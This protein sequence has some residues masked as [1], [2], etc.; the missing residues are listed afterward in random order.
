[1]N[2]II[3]YIIIISAVIMAQKGNQPQT[4]NSV[5]LKKYTGL[6][7]EIAKIPNN[8]QDQCTGGT[9]A[10]YSLEEDGKI[11]VVNSCIDEDGKKDVAEGI[12]KVVDKNTNAK[13]EVSFVSF[14]GIRPF[15]GDYWI[16]GLGDNY[17]YAVVGSPDRKYGWI[18][19]REKQLSKEYLD[20]AFAV[21]KTN[22]YDT[23]KF[24]M[25]KQK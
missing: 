1:M 6:W 17:E 18:L 16:L 22:G 9:T 3:F 10:E 19:A 20:E 8:F 7:Y 12:A 24:E 13:L 2:K 5:D 21:L 4:V 14:L 23:R 11:K 25:T 15:W